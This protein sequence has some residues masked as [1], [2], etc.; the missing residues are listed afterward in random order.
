M[1]G[2]YKTYCSMF[3]GQRQGKEGSSLMQ[4]EQVRG[5][6]KERGQRRSVECK[7]VAGQG[8]VTIILHF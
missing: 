7:E 8:A 4:E 6:G 1:V 3:S 2:M 5:N